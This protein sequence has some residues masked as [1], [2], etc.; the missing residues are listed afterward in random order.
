M[1]LRSR[2]SRRFSGAH[3]RFARPDC[4]ARGDPAL[5]R[6]RFRL[7][8]LS[9][10]QRPHR[11][12]SGPRGSRGG[13][14]C[15]GSGRTRRRDGDHRQSAALRLGAHHRRLRARHRDGR[16]DRPSRRA[17]RP[18]FAH[19][20]RHGDREI[21]GNGRDDRS[22]RPAAISASRTLVVTRRIRRRARRPLAGERAST[23][24]SERRVRT[25]LPAGRPP[26]DAAPR[27]LRGV[28]ALASSDARAD[29]A[30]RL[31]SDRRSERT[32]CRYHRLVPR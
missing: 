9:D 30:R 13:P 32:A 10:R 11:N 29:R 27:R 17:H 8:R 22:G 28:A 7:V 1:G 23:R 6:G 14:R 21:P 20:P 25:V 3:G 5:R 26:C 12:L 18:D 15:Q 24:A 4:A 31:R 19:V 2:S 16:T